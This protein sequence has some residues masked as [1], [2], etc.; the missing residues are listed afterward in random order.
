MSYGQMKTKNKLNAFYLV[1]GLWT[2]YGMVI[3]DNFVLLPN[4]IGFVI[5]TS[6]LGTLH[7]I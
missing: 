4:F 7:F 5:A 2:L 6:Q 1:S 3:A